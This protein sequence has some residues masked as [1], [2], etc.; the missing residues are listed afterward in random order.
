MATA[1]IPTALIPTTDNL[2][3]TITASTTEATNIA[4]QFNNDIT[5]K[6][7][8]FFS[9][10]GGAGSAFNG[11]FLRILGQTFIPEAIVVARLEINNNSGRTKTGNYTAY[12]FGTSTPSGR[13]ETTGGFFWKN[14]SGRI[15]SIDIAPFVA[16]TTNPLFGAGTIFDIVGY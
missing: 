6:Y 11:E 15:T 16:N 1:T 5:A 3:I 10:S 12:E 8:T 14:T 9:A 13:Y 2:I 4:I 7:A